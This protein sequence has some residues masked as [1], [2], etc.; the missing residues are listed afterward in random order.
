M[1]TGIIEEIGKIHS[2]EKNSTTYQLVIEARAVL[3]ETKL[4]DSIAVN[5][6]CL[7]VTAFKKERF[8]VDVMPETLKA[9]S[10]ASLQRGLCVN[11]E[12]ALRAD[13]RLGG[14]FVSGHVDCVGKI[15]QIR[16]AKNAI[17]IALNI[18]QN[19]LRFLVNKGSVA[20][21]GTSLTIFAVDDQAATFTISLIPHT[22]AHTVLGTKRVGDV[23]NIE[24]DMLAKYLQRLTQFPL[25]QFPQHHSQL[26]SDASTQNTSV[27]VTTQL[28]HQTGFI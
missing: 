2:L 22:A 23:V 17:Y 19:Y 28:L 8:T 1:F 11:L 15:V 5:G 20:L 24:C 18:P 27:G 26:D 9:S 4:G 14:H 6:V 3:E 13:S 21:D 10:L 7:T 25:T 12:R 16:P